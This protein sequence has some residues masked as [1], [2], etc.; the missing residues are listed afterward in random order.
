MSELWSEECKLKRRTKGHNS[1]AKKGK[2]III[3]CDTLS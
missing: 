2:A 1:E 3:V